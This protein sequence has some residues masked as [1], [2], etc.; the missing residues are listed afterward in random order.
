MVLTALFTHTKQCVTLFLN[1]ALSGLIAL[2]DLR[3]MMLSD[4]FINE[5]AVCSW[6]KNY[7]LIVTPYWQYFS[8]HVLSM[9]N[10]LLYIFQII[11]SISI[12]FVQVYISIVMYIQYTY[13]QFTKSYVRDTKSNVR[14][15]VTKSYIRYIQLLSYTILNLVCIFAKSNCFLAWITGIYKLCSNIIVNRVHVYLYITI[16]VIYIGMQG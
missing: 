4:Y 14:D 3:G 5:G 11:F 9:S 10:C 7:E 12:E 16:V 8:Q 13:I 1:V 2:Q 15:N 6:N